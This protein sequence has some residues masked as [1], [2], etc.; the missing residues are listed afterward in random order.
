[1]YSRPSAKDLPRR[2]SAQRAVYVCAWLSHLR[3]ELACPSKDRVT[4]QADPGDVKNDAVGRVLPALATSTERFVT[5]KTVPV[6][7]RN[8]KREELNQKAIACGGLAPPLCFLWPSTSGASLERGKLN[9]VGID[10]FQQYMQRVLGDARHSPPTPY[11]PSHGA[12]EINTQRRQG[13]AMES[14]SYQ[15]QLRNA[16]REKISTNDGVA[17]S[18]NHPV[19]HQRLVRGRAGGATGVGSSCDKTL[20][21]LLTECIIGKYKK[22]KCCLFEDK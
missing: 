9:V 7:P 11:S 17:N 4:S 14:S 19:H 15:R 3:G 12:S 10:N 21:K 1:M 22:P 2:A 20:E 5:G 16:V 18:M 13:E 6:F 8:K